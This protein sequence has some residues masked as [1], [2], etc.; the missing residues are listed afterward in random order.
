MVSLILKWVS[1]NLFWLTPFALYAAYWLR[2]RFKKKPFHTG[3]YDNL[4]RDLYDPVGREVA[5]E[6]ISVTNRLRDFYRDFLDGLLFFFDRWFGV[7][8]LNPRAL[9]ASCL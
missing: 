8:W 2:Y 1:E 7:G 3:D 5:I 4:V 6:R 9:R